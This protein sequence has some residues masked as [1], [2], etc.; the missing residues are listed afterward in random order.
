MSKNNIS[1]EYIL[2]VCKKIFIENGASALNMRMVAQECDIALG[3]IYN[4]FPSKG[5]LISEVV[6]SIWIEIFD[7]KN[8]PTKFEK[9]I[10]YLNFIFNNIKNNGAKYPKFFLAHNMLFSKE[11]KT[12]GKE[13]MQNYFDY[14]KK[15][16]IKT[17]DED[18]YINKSFFNAIITKSLYIDY[19]FVLFM[20]MLAK[21]DTDFEKLLTF[22][23]QTL[24]NSKN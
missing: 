15:D 4:Y 24:Y 13:K 9:F 16:L 12:L 14:L 11:E 3:S 2:N 18:K 21:N 6:Q 7:M 19:I 1:K 20:D 17:I 23:E 5:D 8:K 10:D 22:I